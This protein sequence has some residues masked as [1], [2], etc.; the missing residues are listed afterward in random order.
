M[1][2]KVHFLNPAKDDLDEIVDWYEVKSKGLGQLF[3]EEVEKAVAKLERYPNSFRICYKYYHSIL[4][5]RFPYKIIYSIQNDIVLVMVILHDKRG[6]QF[7]RN[8]L[9]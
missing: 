5:K 4:M 9:K 8:R 1:A 7:L 3:L 2:F 6:L